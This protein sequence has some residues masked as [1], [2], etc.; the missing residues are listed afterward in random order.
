MLNKFTLSVIIPV[1]N[2]IENGKYL[3]E[4][5][6]RLKKQTQSNFNILEIILV[7]DSPEYKLEEIFDSSD[8]GIN[9]IIV[10]NNKNQ[11]QAFSRNVGSSIAR[12]DFLHFIDQD[13]LIDTT[14]YSSITNVVDINIT[15]C[16]LFNENNMV[17]HMKKSKQ[18]ILKY[19]NKI[20]T[21]KPFLIFDNIVLSPGQLIISKNVLNI[22]GGFPVLK[23]YGSDDYGFMFKLANNRF[24]YC[25]A[26]NANFFHR[27]HPNQG[28]NILNMKAS[29][30]EYINEYVVKELVFKKLCLANYFPINFFKKALYLLFY[31]RLA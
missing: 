31:N 8:I 30:D 3:N 9:V 2:Y 23:N 20:S 13:D 1:Y 14:F 28:K 11:G 18:L 19:C 12:G 16:F 10:N 21:L 15:N 25:Y 27:L 24:N 4:L 17:L 22:I 5:L 26:F 6:E 7:N 29:K